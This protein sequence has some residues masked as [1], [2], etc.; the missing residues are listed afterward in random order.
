[1][2][3]DGEVR[4][5]HT[6]AEVDVAPDGESIRMRGTAQDVTDRK[7]AEDA[8]TKSERQ[9][10]EAQQLAHIG[11]WEWDQ[12][13]DRVT[14]SAEMRR[15]LGVPPGDRAVGAL[16]VLA[17]VHP[18]DRQRVDETVREAVRNKST[19]SVVF[20]IVR[21]DGD[22]VVLQG[23]GKP[24]L[25]PD[26][27][28][29]GLL[30]THQDITERMA[31]EDALRRAEER[32]RALLD[33]APDAIVGVDDR[34][35]IVLA[36]AQV[37]RLTGYS[38]DELLGEYAVNLAPP[39]ARDEY[40]RR[41]R[42]FFVRG[43]L[44]PDERDFFIQR[45]DGTDL[46]VEVALSTLD[47]E[48]GLLAVAAIRD[49]TERVDAHEI[50]A[51]LEARLHQSE[52]LESVGQ[53][54]GGIAH[55]FNNLLAVILS[56]ARFLRDELD[57]GHPLGD[58]V[59]E[60]EWAAERAADLTH[61]LLIFSRRDKAEPVPLDLNAIVRDTERLLARTIGEHVELSTTFSD[62]SC[63]VLA[64]PGQIEQVLLNLAVNARDAMP[65]GGKL[66]IET[67]CLELDAAEAK[68]RV[69]AGA[70][71]YV[72]LTVS[73]TG[74]GM[75]R[76][77]AARAFEPFFTTK[78]VGEGTGLGLASVYGIVTQADGHI[79]LASEPGVGTTVTAHFPATEMPG[80]RV[81]D[82]DGRPDE[83][84]LEGAGETVLLVED[85]DAVRD[86]TRRILARHGYDVVPAD[87]V[88]DALLTCE[89]HEGDIDLLLTDV[90]M[91]EMSGPDLAERAISLRPG[92]RVLFMSGYTS[93]IVASRGG[94]N[95]AVPFLGKPFT[96]EALLRTVR[97]ALKADARPS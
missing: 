76:E 20:R 78:R 91:P 13:H 57:E 71:R 19:F 48:E 90:V 43:S 29:R 27:E 40:M 80:S 79:D 45:K 23:R 75:N 69:G 24:L 73:D 28:V 37:E 56:Y 10:A 3:S 39:A 93:D 61:Q 64:D 68:A 16:D 42:S 86:L 62:G 6:H 51:R 11:S 2:R 59:K 94:D 22:V 81:A 14:S 63:P 9:L 55:D 1:V 26:G 35:R 12:A 97:E 82:T 67:A 5:I 4:T 7:A 84:S 54:A 83:E 15:I 65:E 8:L 72:R 44:D 18:D 30:G 95:G 85:E 88:H 32:F 74:D 34:G 96:T 92:L 36:N 77:I 49:I 52:R 25:G 89:Q 33:A 87:T 47:S 46:P 31:A 17:L 53:L 60:I 50:E 66:S 38:Y 41:H 70:G 21:P 58:D